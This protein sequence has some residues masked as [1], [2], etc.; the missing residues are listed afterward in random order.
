MSYSRAKRWW[1]RDEPMPKKMEAIAELLRAKGIRVFDIHERW[2][3]CE[4]VPDR[5]WEVLSL[6]PAD[7]A[8]SRYYYQAGASKGGAFELMPKRGSSKSS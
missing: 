7:P 6:Q 3:E 4:F 2:L 5:I 8:W 1:K